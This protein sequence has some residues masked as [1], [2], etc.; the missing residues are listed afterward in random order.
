MTRILRL[1]LPLYLLLEVVATLELAAW[2]GIGRALLLLLLG[3][4]AGITVLRRERLALLA[5]LRRAA[6]LGEPIMPGLL[7][8]ALRALAGI[9]LIVPGFVSDAIGLAL[10]IPAS[11]RWL[12]RRFSAGLGQGRATPGVI[13]GDYR[14]V[15][16]AALP[17]SQKNVNWC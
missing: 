2:L 1:A 10:L 17:G 11:R 12:I 6:N 9:L 7:G 4:I 16:S 15:D 3:A 14:R 13:D 5:L 8:A